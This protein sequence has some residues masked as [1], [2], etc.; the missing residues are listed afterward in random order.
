MGKIFDVQ[1]LFISHDIIHLVFLKI[2]KQTQALPTHKIRY[3][4]LIHWQKPE[5]TNIL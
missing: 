3:Y 1:K 4:Y 5:I 2:R